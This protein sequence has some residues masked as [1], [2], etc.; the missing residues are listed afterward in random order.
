METKSPE[1]RECTKDMRTNISMCV[2]FDSE[3]NSCEGFFKIL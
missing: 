3:H 1:K 2:K